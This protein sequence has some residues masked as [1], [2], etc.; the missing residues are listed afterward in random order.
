MS[1]LSVSPDVVAINSEADIVTAR[2]EGRMLS[3]RLGFACADVTVVGTAICELARNILLYAGNGSITLRPLQDEERQGVLVIAADNGPGIADV[4]KATA[5]GYSTSGGLG[6]GL[7]GVRG[8]VD[9]FEIE[10]DVGRGTTVTVKK[11]SR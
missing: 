9:E 11:W 2:Q 5:G 7:C 8:L 4:A 1:V 10:S 6:L 3:A